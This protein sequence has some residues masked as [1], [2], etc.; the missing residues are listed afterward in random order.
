MY[1]KRYKIQIDYIFVFYTLNLLHCTKT[2]YVYCSQNDDSTNVKV[3]YSKSIMFNVYVNVA[4]VVG[5]TER[6]DRPIKL[7]ILLSN[8]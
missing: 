4:S 6:A 3:V 8:V 1:P 5:W 2:N 7:A